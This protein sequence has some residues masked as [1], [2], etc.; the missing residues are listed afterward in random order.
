MTPEAFSVGE[1]AEHLG[2]GDEMIRHC[3]FR[4]RLISTTRYG[5]C[6]RMNI[7]PPISYVA[8]FEFCLIMGKNPMR[9]R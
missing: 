6:R 1:L 9:L 4:R 8:A 2:L 7:D 5:F 3:I